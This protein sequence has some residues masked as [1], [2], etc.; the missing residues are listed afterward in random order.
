MYHRSEMEV[1]QVRNIV[2]ERPL[3]EQDQLRR[4]LEYEKPKKSLCPSPCDSKEVT[5]KKVISSRV[6]VIEWLSHY[7][8]KHDLMSDIVSGI[9]V[10][11]MHI[12][13]GMAY[14]LLANVPA[15]VGIYM[16]F[17]PVLVYFIFGTSRHNSM[18][19]FAVVCLMTG[20]AVLEHSDP[21]Y[22]RSLDTIPMS[23]NT[24][25]GYSPMQV[26]STVTFTV[27]M[28]QIAMHILKLGAVSAVLSETLVSGFTTGAAIQVTVSQFKD[29]LGLRI[30]KF[31]GYFVVYQTL[32]AI[33]ENIGSANTAALI[34]SAVTISV[35]SFNNEVLKPLVAKRSVFPIPIELIAV[36][37][38]S[39]VSYYCNLADNYGVRVVGDI[40]QGL[41]SPELPQFALIPAV[42]VDGLTIAI[43]SY[44]VTL[45]MALIF[46]QKLNYE[47]D[48][49]QELLALGLSNI[50]GSCFHCVSICAS[51]SRSLIQQVVGGK[52]QVVSLVSCSILVVILLWIG[53]FFE[54]LPKSVLASVI[55]VALKG[56]LL[57]VKDLVRFWKLSK[58]DA[59]IWLITCLS[60]VVIGIDIGLLAGVAVSLVAI[61]ALNFRP[62]VCL[63]GRVPSTDMYVDLS[64]Y[65][66]AKQIDGV[67]IFQYS[68]G[69]NFATRNI[70]KASLYELIEL[71]PQK[72]LAYRTKLAQKLENGED[73]PKENDVHKITKLKQKV[74]FNM[75]CVI[76]DFSMVSYID[77]SGISMMKT[78]VE[79]FKK[80]DISVYVCGCNDPVY[81]MMEKCELIKTLKP[82]LRVFQ[83]I[84]DA[85]NCSSSL[86]G[87]ALDGGHI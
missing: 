30:P 75:K 86:F 63:L 79:G 44:A 57:Q 8:W 35:T 50:V 52:T 46:A 32:H 51:L 25:T 11:I 31:K 71:N 49:N 23:L 70:F 5:L 24:S 41:P 2:I 42:I 80:L 83:S 4:D 74:N 54:P 20:K 81:D 45:S 84:H 16:A 7:N 53:P 26:A 78:V 9:T 10:A 61:L 43:V 56:M 14:A 64:R 13:Q 3:Y 39:T 37:L 47:I 68:G 87:I 34:I 17:F 15:I 29:L 59:L 72:E 28:F 62:Y 69:I 6:P 66:Q 65:R 76:L 21:V 18:G 48:S 67:K 22:F 58:M 1:S 27:A 38:G 36:V 12:P 82:S 73:L 77:P 85:V 60:V 19:T 40:P 55:V 33:A